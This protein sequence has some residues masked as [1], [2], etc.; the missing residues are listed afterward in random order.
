MRQIVTLASVL[1]LKRHSRSAMTERLS[2]VTA[3]RGYSYCHLRWNTR[4]RARF[5]YMYSSPHFLNLTKIFFLFV[6]SMNI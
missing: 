5:C 4:V 1:E 6:F 3:G 2:A